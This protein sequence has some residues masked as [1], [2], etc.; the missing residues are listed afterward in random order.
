MDPNTVYILSDQSR[1]STD[2]D[3]LLTKSFGNQVTAVELTRNVFPPT[4]FALLPPNSRFF[5]VRE[6][7]PFWHIV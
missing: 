4:R 5:R 6:P 7:V 3:T 1:G 2:H